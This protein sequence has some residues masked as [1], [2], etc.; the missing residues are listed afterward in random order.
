[1]STFR[2][3]SHRKAELAQER[4]QEHA[5][6][7]RPV[8]EPNFFR[9]PS[10]NAGGA[11]LRLRRKRQFLNQSKSGIN[12]YAVVQFLSEQKKCIWPRQIALGYCDIDKS[13]FSV[14]KI[15]N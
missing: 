14:D 2:G 4:A 7:R 5:R 12:N 1:M 11:N 9:A 8:K 10:F 13:T 15:S 3:K 6:A